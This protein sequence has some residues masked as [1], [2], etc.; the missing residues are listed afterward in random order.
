MYCMLR[1]VCYRKIDHVYACLGCSLSRHRQQPATRND[2]YIGTRT[3]T[4]LKNI[5]DGFIR[6]LRVAA[7]T[8]LATCIDHIVTSIHHFKNSQSTG[9]HPLVLCLIGF[10]CQIT[11]IFAYLIVCNNP[12]RGAIATDMLAMAGKCL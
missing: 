8:Y 1:T 9:A 4:C 5:H 6:N 11:M 7:P 3:Q 2:E 10:A 12:K